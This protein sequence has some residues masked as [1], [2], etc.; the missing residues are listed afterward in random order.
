MYEEAGEIWDSLDSE[1]REKVFR[2]I[3]FRYRYDMERRDPFLTNW[4]GIRNKGKW[5]PQLYDAIMT[6]F[7]KEEND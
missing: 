5:Y 1:G 6:L 2:H 4:A 3:G 7:G